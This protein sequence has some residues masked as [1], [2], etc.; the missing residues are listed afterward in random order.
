MAVLDHTRALITGLASAIGLPDL[1]PDETG[2]FHLQVGGT[3]DVFIYGG[4]DIDILVVVPV[5]PLPPAPGYAL[6]TYL[7]HSNMFNAD[8]AP[9]VIAADD[10]GGVILWGKLCIADLDGTAL[11]RIVDNLTERAATMRAALLP[12]PHQE[13]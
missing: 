10:A 6:V 9:F 13:P 7:L 8:I 1:P 3:E 2:G 11:A 5:A 12:H 4:D